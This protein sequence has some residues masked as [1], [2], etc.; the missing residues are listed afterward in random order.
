MLILE[1]TVGFNLTLL[2]KAIASPTLYSVHFIIMAETYS[3]TAQKRTPGKDQKRA[4]QANRQVLAV[5]YGYQFDS[6]P[7][8]VDASDVLRTYRKAG[9]AGVI[10]LDIDGKKSQVIVKELVLHPVTDEIMHV[11]FFAVNP[12]EK[13]TV[14]VPFKFLGEAPAVKTLG[15]VFTIAHEAVEIR[16]LPSQI[17]HDFPVDITHLKNMG[18]SIKLQDLKLNSQYEVM[19]LDPEI[20]IASVAGKKSNTADET[21]DGADAAETES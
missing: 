2:R 19:D 3:L 21:E 14:K 17:P 15:G 13:T 5:V 18:D 1:N 7:I 11:D 8:S 10:D 16:C 9:S 20:I 4:L 12:K 6:E